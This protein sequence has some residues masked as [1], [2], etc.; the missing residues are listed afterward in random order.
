MLQPH[1]ATRTQMVR[2]VRA[3]SLFLAR[4]IV[5]GNSAI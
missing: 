3:A 4:S 1:K 2:D 5:P